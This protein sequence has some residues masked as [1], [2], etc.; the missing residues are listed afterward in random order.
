MADNFISEMRKVIPDFNLPSLEEVQR[1]DSPQLTKLLTEMK[2]SSDILV[3]KEVEF[4][5]KKDQC[6][7]ELKELYSELTEKYNISSKEELEA[8]IENSNTELSEVYKK[9]LE[10][11]SETHN[12]VTP[13]TGDENA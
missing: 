8:H 11:N 5:T 9:V 6:E 3:K 7:K 4:S 2:N 10:F 1:M 13:L 12:E